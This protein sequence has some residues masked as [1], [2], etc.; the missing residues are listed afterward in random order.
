MKSFLQ[1][2]KSNNNIKF[3]KIEQITLIKNLDLYDLIPKILIFIYKYLYKI[4]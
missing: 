3:W 2:I 4:K 1:K